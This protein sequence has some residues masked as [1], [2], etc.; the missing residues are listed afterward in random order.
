MTHNTILPVSFCP[1]CK[2][3]LDAATGISMNTQPRV[4]DLSLCFYCGN[5]LKFCADLSLQVAFKED[6]AKLR[7]E[8]RSRLLLCQVLIEHKKEK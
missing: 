2:K 5:V 4:G 1:M 3:K 6:I 7:K 8:D